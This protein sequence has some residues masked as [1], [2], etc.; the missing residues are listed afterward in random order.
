MSVDVFGPY[1][2]ESAI[3]RVHGS[4]PRA[5]QKPICHQVRVHGCD[6]TRGI[7]QARANYLVTLGMLT[8]LEVIGGLITGDGGLI[9]KSRANFNAALAH[10]P[11][12]Y[13]AFQ[14]TI[15]RPGTTP[16]TGVY[17][18]LRCS[19]VHQ[20]TPS[21]TFM[22]YANPGHRAVA[23]R[24]GFEWETLPSGSQRLAINANELLRDFKALL[25]IVRHWISSQD[26]LYYPLIK[27]ALERIDGFQLV[28]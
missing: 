8:Y 1:F 22:V 3:V 11:P 26:A 9:G 17:E 28:P 23:G 2:L 25:V 20:Y 6:I 16:V 12:A 10:M 7:H 27:N 21:E 19:L 24:L 4:N 5:G 13:G 15:L 18:I 14:V